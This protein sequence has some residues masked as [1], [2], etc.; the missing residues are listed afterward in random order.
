M[1]KNIL[2]RALIP[3][4]AAILT[5]SGSALASPTANYDNLKNL[6]PSAST[7][8]NKTVTVNLSTSSFTHVVSDNNVLNAKVTVTFTAGPDD[9][10]IYVTSAKGTL[11]SETTIKKDDPIT[12]S[13]PWGDGTWSLSAKAKSSAQ[14]AAFSIKD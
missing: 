7:K 14:S 3:A 9:A 13:V 6:I 12:F 10:I 5:F 2:F 4:I 1:K 11:V 8:I